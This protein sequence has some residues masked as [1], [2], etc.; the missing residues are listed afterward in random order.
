[1]RVGADDAVGGGVDAFGKLRWQGDRDRLRLLVDQLTGIDRI[2]LGVEDADG[3]EAR[4][5][6]FVEP[7]RDLLGRGLERGTGAGAGLLEHGMSGCERG[8]AERHA[9]RREGCEDEPHQTSPSLSASEA[10]RAARRRMR[11]MKKPKLPSTAAASPA[12]SAIDGPPSVGTQVSVPV[13]CA[14]LPSTSRGTSQSKTLLSHRLVADLRR[15]PL[16]HVV[17]PVVVPVVRVVRGDVAPFG[18]GLGVRLRRQLDLG[19][20]VLVQIGGR[21]TLVDLHRSVAE[22]AQ[23]GLLLIAEHDDLTAWLGPDLNPVVEAEHLGVDAGTRTGDLRSEVWVA[24]MGDGR[25]RRERQ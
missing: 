24:L 1:M 15:R 17:D 4:L 11:Q 21:R 8:R 18:R 16:A 12:S 25:G 3:A 22:E 19:E 10:G 6:R 2:A 14:G 5:D 13:T 23:V 7:K 9:R 20:A